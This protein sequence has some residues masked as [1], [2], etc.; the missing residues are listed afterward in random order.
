M[1]ITEVKYMYVCMYVY[2]EMLNMLDLIENVRNGKT[3]SEMPEHA[4]NQTMQDYQKI[5]DN[6]EVQANQDER[7][8]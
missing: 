8:A 6:F 4:K 7:Y 5:Q 1:I 3:L 2:I